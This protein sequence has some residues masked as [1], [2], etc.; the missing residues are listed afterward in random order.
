MVKG[1]LCNVTLAGKNEFRDCAKNDSS[2]RY[3]PVA[4]HG[5][6]EVPIIDCASVVHQFEQL[7]RDGTIKF[8]M[9]LE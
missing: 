6:F 2:I 9:C 5:I 1:Q 3:T 8:W 7:S 4:D